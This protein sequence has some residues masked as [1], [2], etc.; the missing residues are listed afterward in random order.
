[1][2]NTQFK[3]IQFSLGNDEAGKQ[4]ETALLTSLSNDLP[5]STNVSFVLTAKNLAGEL[6][7][8][9]TA[10]TSYGWFLVKVVWVKD[11]FRGCGLGRALMDK[12]EEKARNSECH[13]LWL[14]TSN[15]DAKRFYDSL[16]FTVFGEL[17]N[18]PDQYPPEHSRWFMKKA[19]E[20]LSHS[21]I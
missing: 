9:L 18:K 14:D 7:G 20:S 17:H 10:S 15:P 8:G 1:M 13:S 3:D 5:Q 19:L 6:I 11:D 12:A 16:G 2:Q 21:S 4:I